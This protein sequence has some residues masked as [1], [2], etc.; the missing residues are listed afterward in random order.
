[1]KPVRLRHISVAGILA[2]FAVAFVAPRLTSVGTNIVTETYRQATLRFF[3]GQ[4]PY[5]LMPGG[6]FFQYSPF[7]CVFYAPFAWLPLKTQALA[8]ALANSYLFWI[9]VLVWIPWQDDRVK[10]RWPLI[11]ALVVASMELNISL[12]YQQVNALLIGLILLG[13]HAYRHKRYAIAGVVLGLASIL[14]VLPLLFALALLFPFRRNYWMALGASLFVTIGIPEFFGPNADWMSLQWLETLKRASEMIR[15]NQLDIISTTK[16]LGWSAVSSLVLKW[17]VIAF[18]IPLFFK[19]PLRGSPRWE[20]WI[21]LGI[22][23]LLLV[24]PRSESPTFVLLAPSYPLMAVYLL[25][26][27]ASW[28]RA[29]FLSLLSISALAITVI[30]T[31]LWPRSIPN[32]LRVHYLGKPV[33]TLLLW[34]LSALI[35]TFGSRLFRPLWQDTRS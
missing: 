15:D 5:G 4:L 30:F 34:G 21:T 1:M 9:G 10:Q 29:L 27:P 24:S 28:N 22:C 19:E 17:G 33:G 35:L 2:I 31:D 8:W 6:D 23:L 20:V 11:V 14:K 12:L 13:L 25:R 3:A 18:T 7:F 16:R 32:A 26:Q